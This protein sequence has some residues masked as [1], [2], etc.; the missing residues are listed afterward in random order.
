MKRIIDKQTMLFLRD[1][2]QWN[3][4]LEIALEVEPDNESAFVHPKWDG[5]KWVE[6]SDVI[7]EPIEEI[8]LPTLEERL[9]ALEQLE[10][11]RM[12]EL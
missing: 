4:E 2:T 1:D 5:E 7:P 12:F 10:L 3:E 11:E 6:G 8:K 9:Q